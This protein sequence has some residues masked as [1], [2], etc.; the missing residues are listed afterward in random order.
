MVTC[1]N[2]LRPV[3]WVVVATKTY[4]TS[5]TDPW[6]DA[7]VGSNTRIAVLRNGVEHLEPFRGRTPADRLIP[8]V[9]DI[10]AERA[11][12][13]QVNQRRAGWMRVP[14]GSASDAFVA[15]FADSPIDVTV[16]DDFKTEAW[17]KLAL[18]CAGAVNAL[19][20]QTAWIAHDQGA[21]SV[22]RAL[23]EECVAVGRAEG[24]KLSDTLAETVITAYRSGPQ[25]GMNSMH[26]DRLAGRPMELDA[27]NGVI[28]RLG[29]IHGV[30][31]PANGMIVSLLTAAALTP[32]ECRS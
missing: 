13:G 25:D 3:D 18:N 23:V 14:R 24:A 32:G 17:K 6:L 19:T 16:V 10:P 29:A 28:V 1:A 30:P 12:P 26:A 15:L 21:A 4:D 8:V 2:E 31:T 5:A 22:M 9:V 20:L 11:A 27:R 7:L